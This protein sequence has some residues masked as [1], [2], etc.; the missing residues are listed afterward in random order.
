MTFRPKPHHPIL[1][2]K[3]IAMVVAMKPG[4]IAYGSHS[5]SS[6]SMSATDSTS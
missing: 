1:F 3:C 6:E 2:P 4:G 5:R